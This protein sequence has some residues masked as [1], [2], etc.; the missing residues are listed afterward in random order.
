MHFIVAAQI[1]CS[2]LYVGTVFAGAWH[3]LHAGAS[4]W[5]V[6]QVRRRRQE[7]AAQGAI[8]QLLRQVSPTLS[9]LI[10][11]KTS[12]PPKGKHLKEQLDGQRGVMGGSRARDGKTPHGH[13]RDLPSPSSAICGR[14]ST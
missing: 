12:A 8:G 4:A 2:A 11:F 1:E 10:P 13:H 7:C 5:C 9:S 6:I 3:V 14:A